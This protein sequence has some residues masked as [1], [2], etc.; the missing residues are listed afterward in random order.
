MAEGNKLECYF[1]NLI[2][3]AD[4]ECFVMLHHPYRILS[5]SLRSL[6]GSAEQ[7]TN[8]CYIPVPLTY[9][10]R[11]LAPAHESKMPCLVEVTP[12]GSLPSAIVANNAAGRDT[13]V[14]SRGEYQRVMQTAQSI[15]TTQGIVLHFLKN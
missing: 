12:Q 2:F 10:Y 13:F 15:A 1:E 3:Y 14:L 7:C 8:A 6:K 9:E 5:A 11:T 4:G